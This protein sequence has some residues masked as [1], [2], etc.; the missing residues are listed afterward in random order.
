MEIELSRVI[1]FS[2][3]QDGEQVKVA[4]EN[5]KGEQF[6][7]VVPWVALTDV[8]VNLQRVELNLEIVRK[9]RGI[10]FR[11]YEFV[12]ADPLFIVNALGGIVR[13]DGQVDLRIAEVMGSTFQLSIPKAQS[14]ILF[15]LLFEV[16]AASDD[17]K[18]N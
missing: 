12:E 17:D 15:D 4:C 18:L 10:S 9:S 13:P 7:L 16:F 8:I 2:T 14:Q 6:D 5:E 3:R 1:N 11:H